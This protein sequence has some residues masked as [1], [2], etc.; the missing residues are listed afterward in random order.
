MFETPLADRD[1]HRYSVSSD[2]WI[3][4][5][6]NGNYFGR[7]TRPCFQRQVHLCFCV[8]PIP[9]DTRKPTCPQILKQKEFLELVE[10]DND[11]VK[12][13]NV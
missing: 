1:I 2:V 10:E 12:D 9:L 3:E 6:E 13:T 11:T 4:C 5:P 8:Q 7:M